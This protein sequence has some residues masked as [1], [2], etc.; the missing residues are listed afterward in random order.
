[1]KIP[2]SSNK[3][4]PSGFTLTEVIVA[5]GIFTFAITSL[6][7]VIPFGMNQ[8]Q[9]A[10]NEASALSNMEAIRDDVSLALSSGAEKSLRYEIAMPSAGATSPIELLITEDGEIQTGGG[11]AI[12]R[13]A[14][15][16]TRSADTAGEP[17]HFHLRSTWPAQTPAG[18]ET[19]SVELVTA[20]QP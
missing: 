4:Q 10:S 5:L 19:G 8:V 16:L 6:M 17:V 13:I 7:G 18:R 12:F 11:T 14:G 2:Q 20:F 1:M 15:T 9:V 3:N